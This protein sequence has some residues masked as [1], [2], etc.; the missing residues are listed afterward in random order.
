MDKGGMGWIHETDYSVVNI[1]GKAHGVGEIG[2]GLIGKSRHS[3]NVEGRR[4]FPG[5]GSA[6]SDPEIALYLLKIV[7]LHIKPTA[8]H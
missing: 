4:A 5:R 2:L 8:V 6:M 3:R 1:A 7:T